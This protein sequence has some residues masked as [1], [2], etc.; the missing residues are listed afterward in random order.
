MWQK[1]RDIARANRVTLRA[2][3]LA[4]MFVDDNL[5]VEGGA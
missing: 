1:N 5:P 4:E 3:K 2:Q